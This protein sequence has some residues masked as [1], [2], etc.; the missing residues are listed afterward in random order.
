M[1]LFCVLSL[2]DGIMSHN[3]SS[4]TECCI[5]RSGHKAMNEEVFINSG[6]IRLA[7]VLRRLVYV[8]YLGQ[9]TY[10]ALF[11]NW[12]RITNTIIHHELRKH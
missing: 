9:P 7:K 1:I 8:R 2:K 4:L 3:K 5:V 6:I 12:T 10:V 11:V